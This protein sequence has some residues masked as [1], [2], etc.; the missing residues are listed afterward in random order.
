MDTV[1]QWGA[2]VLMDELLG[3]GMWANGQS[4]WSIY[5]ANDRGMQTM[6]FVDVPPGSTINVT[7]TLRDAQGMILDQDFFSFV[8]GAA[9]A[10]EAVIVPGCD[11]QIDIPATAVVGTFVADT[12]LYYEPGLKIIPEEVL[13]AGQSLWVLGVDATGGYYKVLLACGTYWA[14]VNTLGPTY[15]A[16]WNGT[17]L[18]TNVVE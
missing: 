5:D 1:A 9:P 6:S 13:A 3:P 4:H 12:P 14:P 7:L 8:C 18:P 10:E 16:V 2:E 11:M 17:P 15:D